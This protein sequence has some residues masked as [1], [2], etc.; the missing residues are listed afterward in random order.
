MKPN[1]LLLEFQDT[2]D[3]FAWEDLLSELQLLLDKKNP[4][5]HWFAK[6]ENF[7]WL[8]Q[9]G[10]KE[11]ETTDARDFLQSIL[12]ETDCTFKIFE[13][14]DGLA[15]QNYHHDSPTGNEWY[16][17]TPRKDTE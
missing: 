11:F 5:G 16:Y 10:T 8:N 15:I 3:E 14:E 4:G 12:P 1:K 6:V 7:G 17:I 2:E 13:Y 9:S